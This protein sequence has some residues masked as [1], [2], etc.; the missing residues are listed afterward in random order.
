M[1]RKLIFIQTLFLTIAICLFSNF[2]A[3]QRIDPVSA[4]QPQV[5]TTSF[6]ELAGSLKTTS[7]VKITK[8]KMFANNFT[9]GLGSSTQAACESAYTFFFNNT[10]TVQSGTIIY[11]DPSLSTPVTWGTLVVD[12]S[13]NKI[14]N[15]NASTSTIGT[16][17]G[18]YCQ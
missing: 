13:T 18:N 9:G 11:W 6:L 3:Q 16:F 5:V 4:N 8:T 7:N 10:L 14:Y 17:T 1:K 12:H 15:F 2:Q